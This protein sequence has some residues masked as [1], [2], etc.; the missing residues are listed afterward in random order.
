MIESG[1]DLEKTLIQVPLPALRRA[2][3]LLQPA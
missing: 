2:A 1:E 3:G